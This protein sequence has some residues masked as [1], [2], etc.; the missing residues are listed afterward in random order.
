MV[1]RLWIIQTAYAL[2]FARVICP[3]FVHHLAV[4]NAYVVV[5]SRRRDMTM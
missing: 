2:L 5:V 1:V 3:I 4:E